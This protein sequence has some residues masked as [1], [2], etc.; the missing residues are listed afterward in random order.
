MNLYEAQRSNRNK[1]ALLMVLFIVF[2]AI[3]GF[4]F[5]YFYLGFK[6]AVL[7]PE[8]ATVQDQR[9][10]PFPFATLAALVVA[11]LFAASSYRWGDKMVLAST[12][13]RRIE[14]PGN[15]QERQL[16]NVVEEITIASGT[17]MPKVYV[18]PD[19]DL[20][21]FATGRN[22]QHASIAV[23]QGLLDSLNREELQGVIAHELSHVK[24][25]DIRCMTLIAALVGAVGL[26]GD[27]SLRTMTYRGGRS[28][29][30]S[31]QGGGGAAAI[32]FAVWFIT[33]LLAPILGRILAMAV[34]RQREY[35]ADATGAELTRNPL[36]L[37]GALQKLQAAVEPTK[38][39]KQGMAHLCIVDPLALAIDNKQGVWAN[40]FATHPPMTERIRRL[41]AMAYQQG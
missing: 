41:N 35:L 13:A 10:M 4:G 40:L 3:L 7:S 29:S 30:S 28:R 16:L 32:F 37:A 15:A 31:R 14:Q 19:P 34:S 36:G 33:A 39:I 23:T 1:T 9:A 12:R 25:H 6:P 8:E 20:N 22:P 11:S 18:V 26:L 21:A 17:P 5:D 27:W 24:N 2:F 38:S